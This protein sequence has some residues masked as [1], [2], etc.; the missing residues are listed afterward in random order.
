MS[1]GEP[2]EEKMV[3]DYVSKWY[4]KRYS[5]TGLLYHSRIVH[6]MLQGFTMKHKTLDV[7][8][9]TGFVSQLYPNFDITG[10]DISDGMLANNPYK[11]VKA[12]AEKIPFPNESFD[13]VICRSLL[14]HLELPLLGLQEMHRVL[15]PGGRFVAWETNFSFLNDVVRRIARF[16]PRFSH[17]HKNFKSKELIYML[18]DSKFIVTDVRY[19]GY[20]AYP[21]TGFPDIINLRI[22]IGFARGL[23]GIDDL[24][25]KTPLRRL[26]WSILIKATK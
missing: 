4:P 8:C 25:S 19:R 23:L 16:T 24:L 3:Q 6:E 11:W 18:E 7:G 10:I 14:H 5:G 9:G 17:W 15:K 1:I 2:T 13:Y 20:I 21:L 26:A 12:A 22:P